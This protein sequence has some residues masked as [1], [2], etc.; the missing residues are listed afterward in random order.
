MLKCKHKCTK[1][2][3]TWECTFPYFSKFQFFKTTVNNGYYCNSYCPTCQSDER[4]EMDDLF[5]NM[6]ENGYLKSSI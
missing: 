4:A 6:S 1:C 5:D 3:E 2:E